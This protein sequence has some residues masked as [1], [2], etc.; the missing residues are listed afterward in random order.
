MDKKE[1][2]SPGQGY[3]SINAKGKQSV[4]SGSRTNP[5][6]RETKLK[7]KERLNTTLGAWKWK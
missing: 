6:Q 4:R 7:V 2:K 5:I 3:G 1:E